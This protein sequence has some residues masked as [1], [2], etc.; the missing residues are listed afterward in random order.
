[1]HSTSV[2]DPNPG[3]GAFWTNGSGIWNRFFP[4]LGSQ[5]HIF[6]E[7]NVNFLGKKLLYNSLKIDQFFF[8]SVQ[9]KIIFNFVIFVA[10]KKVGQKFFP[11]LSFVA[12][13][14]SRIRYPG[15]GIRDG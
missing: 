9:N 12:V 3:S 6:W 8:S 11:S 14:G 1:M 15:R 10:T 7:L 2:A 4:D 5:N 13:F